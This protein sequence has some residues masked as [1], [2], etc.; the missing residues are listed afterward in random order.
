MTRRG[1]QFHAIEA[2]F[3]EEL[4]LRQDPNDR[5]FTLGG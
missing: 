1:A 4:S 5:F 3:A 2:T